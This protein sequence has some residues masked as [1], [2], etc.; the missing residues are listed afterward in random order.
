MMINAETKHDFKTVKAFTYLSAF[1][2]NKPAKKVLLFSLITVMLLVIL[3]LSMRLLEPGAFLVTMFVV[4][5]LLL[6]T[7]L[8]L[9]IG[10]PIIRYR[11]MG[12]LMN[13]R[14]QFRFSDEV[15]TVV[16]TDDG[17]EDECTLMYKKV[18][19]VLETPDYFYI[20]HS[21]TQQFIVDKKSLDDAEIEPLRAKLM[22]FVPG[23]YKVFKA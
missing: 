19:K 9:F 20:F 15:F 4:T 6:L 17:Y 22:G 12:N 5:L 14:Q 21:R 23:R 3:W 13:C 11:S 18:D 16:T 10:L 1:R 7:E 8:F 2:T